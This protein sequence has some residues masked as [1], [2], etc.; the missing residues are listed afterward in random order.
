MPSVHR[1][2]DHR[3]PK[4]YITEADRYIQFFAPRG[5]VPGV[6]RPFDHP[7]L[8]EYLFFRGRTTKKLWGILSKLKWLG[9][10]YGHVLPTE[11]S[12]QPSLL[13]QRI[14][15]SIRRI[16]LWIKASRGLA[17]V[18]ALALDNTAAVVVVSHFMCY[19]RRAMSA[20]P[21]RDI[22]Y[23]TQSVM[24]HS[25]CLRHGHFSAHDVKRNNLS[26]PPMAQ[27]WRLE[28]HWAKYDDIT[29]VFFYDMPQAS[30]GRYHLLRPQRAPP[31]TVTASLIIT[32]YT[33][34]RDRRFPDNQL[35]F[36]GMP[37]MS[38]RKTAYTRWLRAVFSAALP[39]FPS[40]FLRIVRPHGWRAGWVCDRRKQ[41]TPDEVTMREG[42][43]SSKV[44]M[45]L[46]D[47]TAFSVVCP[48]SDIIFA[49]ASAGR[50]TRI[51]R[52]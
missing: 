10:V 41:G 27:G 31:V 2:P 46:Y 5:A 9:M 7:A 28:S 26:R 22:V 1:H 25:G 37:N 50:Q 40:K 4:S 45:G 29:E 8:E 36:P 39:A 30:P 3:R 11:S 48:V 49:T 32:W 19:N 33:T 51:K 21:W 24:A 15:D 42:R 6:H 16:T 43:W 14:K 23:I 17:V 12:Q 34:I 20:L 18:R 35:L 44:A 38:T 52:R 13:F 47:R